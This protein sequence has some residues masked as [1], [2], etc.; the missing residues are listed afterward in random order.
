MRAKETV[1]GNRGVENEREGEIKGTFTGKKEGG[2]KKVRRYA[3]GIKGKRE[4][5]ARKGR[6]GRERGKKILKEWH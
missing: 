6:E 5:N 2:G 1:D 4:D 3:W